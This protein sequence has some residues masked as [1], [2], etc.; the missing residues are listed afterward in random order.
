MNI[1][2]NQNPVLPE[3]TMAIYDSIRILMKR[4]Y[5]HSPND[6]EFVRPGYEPVFPRGKDGSEGPIDLSQLKWAAEKGD[7]W[8]DWYPG[9]FLRLEISKEKMKRELKF[10]PTK[11]NV[12]EFVRK[13]DQD[14]K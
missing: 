13:V 8:F 14:F 1:A 6:V 2:V 3:W 9:S 5:L 11:K 10:D 4:G 7:F 12:W